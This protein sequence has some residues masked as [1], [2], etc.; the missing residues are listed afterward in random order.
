MRIPAKYPLEYQNVDENSL[1]RLLQKGPI[2]ITIS[3]DN[4][5]YYGGGVFSCPVSASVNH[6]VLLVGYT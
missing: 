2:A 5:E 1:I 4:W 6:G 3:A